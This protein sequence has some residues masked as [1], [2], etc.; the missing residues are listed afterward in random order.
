ML[1]PDLIRVDLLRIKRKLYVSYPE[2]SKERKEFMIA[3][4]MSEL[5]YLQ[6]LV[7]QETVNLVFEEY[8]RSLEGEILRFALELL[9]GSCLSVMFL[10]LHQL[11][12]ANAWFKFWAIPGISGLFSGCT[13][14]YHMIVG[15]KSIQPFKAEYKILQGKIEKIIKELKELTK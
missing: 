2:G 13:H 7:P 5:T 3:A 8:F 12:P 11:H 1:D 10:A 15:W 4:K 14:I 6:H 9:L